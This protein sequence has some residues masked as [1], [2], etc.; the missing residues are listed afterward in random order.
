MCIPNHIWSA[1]P[2]NADPHLCP[3]IKDKEGDTALDLLQPGDDELRR[4]IRKSQAENSVS[5]G[6]IADDGKET[7]LDASMQEP[8]D[9]ADD[10]EGSAGSGS[11]S[12]SD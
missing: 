12:E 9:F 7:I 1:S 3:R 2:T 4:L 8:D 6:D 11:G 5:K 10:D